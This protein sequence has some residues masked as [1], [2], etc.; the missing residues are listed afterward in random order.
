[1]HV[2][3]H[4]VHQRARPIEVVTEDLFQQVQGWRRMRMSWAAIGRNLGVNAEDARRRFE[5]PG[6]PR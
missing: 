5:T 3:Q 2:G 6:G 1:M 4:P